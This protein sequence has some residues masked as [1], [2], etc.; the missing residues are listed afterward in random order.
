MYKVL[1]KFQN[2]DKI[3]ENK[4]LSLFSNFYLPIEILKQENYEKEYKTVEYSKDEL[5]KKSINELDK[6]LKKQIKNE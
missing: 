1:S 6:E 5:K 4:K 3:N 2:Y